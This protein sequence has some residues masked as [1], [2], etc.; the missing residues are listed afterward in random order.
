MLDSENSEESILSK[1]NDKNTPII[2][3]FRDIPGHKYNHMDTML[4]TVLDG[5]HVRD[6]D[7]THL[8]GKTEEDASWQ[9]RCE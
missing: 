7:S 2:Q 8:D 3:I 6:K 1:N 9:D 4:A 5:E